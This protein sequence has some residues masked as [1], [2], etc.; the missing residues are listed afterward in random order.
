MENLYPVASINNLKICKSDIHKY[1]VLIIEDND[2]LRNYLKQIL[3]A[4]YN[5]YESA[6]GQISKTILEQAFPDLILC[7]VMLPDINGLTLCKSFKENEKYAHIPIIIMTAKQ[8]SETELLGYKSG[9]DDYITKPF[10]TNILLARISNLLKSRTH[11]KEA[12]QKGERFNEISRNEDKEFLKSI[13]EAILENLE[14]SDFTKQD[15]VRSMNISRAHLYRKIQD[16]TGK[17]LGQFIRDIKM[18]K[19]LYLIENTS[20]TIK[21]IA[22][23]TG[24]SSPANFSREFKKYFGH[25]PAFF[26]R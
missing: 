8:S 13:Y 16:L 14:N 20:L 11:L 6:N 23:K 12:I 25:S 5:I 26:R 7:D 2:D 22:F 19:A 1:S 4:Y 15:L 21:E 17:S 9:V 18:E 10:N 24:F 3:S